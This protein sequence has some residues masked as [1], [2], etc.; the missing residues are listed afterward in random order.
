MAYYDPLRGH[1]KLLSFMSS[2]L[3]FGSLK[4]IIFKDH[5]MFSLLQI[6][7]D[8][9]RLEKTFEKFYVEAN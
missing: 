7:D 4:R 5:V 1:F 9:Y 2:V 3:L 8:Y 6:S